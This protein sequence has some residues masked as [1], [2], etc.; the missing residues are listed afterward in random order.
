MEKNFL[1]AL[2]ETIREE[3]INNNTVQIDGFGRFEKKHQNQ[4]QK[5]F[6]NGRIVLLPPRD[7]I[8][9]SSEITEKP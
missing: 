2:K 4:R 8:T 9:F 7:K 1:K 5:K 6:E 3:I